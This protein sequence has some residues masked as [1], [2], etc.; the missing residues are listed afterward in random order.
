MY[1]KKQKNKKKKT[2]N[3]GCITFIDFVYATSFPFDLF[4]GGSY[5]FI[6]IRSYG[7]HLFVVNS[8][9]NIS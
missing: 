9:R 3:I 4:L 8:K 6:S 5:G 1:T 7:W 2:R